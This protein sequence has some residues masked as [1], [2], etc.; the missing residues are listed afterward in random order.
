MYCQ[1]KEALFSCQNPF[2]NPYLRRSAFIPLAKLGGDFVCNVNRQKQ[3][4]FLTDRKET[5]V[6]R[7]CILQPYVPLRF[8]R[9]QTCLEENCDV[10]ALIRLQTKL[11]F[12]KFFQM[13]Y[14]SQGYMGCRPLPSVPH[15]LHVFPRCFL[16]TSIHNR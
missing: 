16:L 12:T 4:H 3:S 8:V 14:S 11:L 13:S 1:E 7:L 10:S 9:V 15:K 2:K 5:P 6:L